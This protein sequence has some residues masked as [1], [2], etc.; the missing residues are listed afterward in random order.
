[1]GT[2]A[3]TLM[4]GSRVLLTTIDLQAEG[5]VASYLRA[6]RPYFTSPV[7]VMYVGAR[8]GASMSKVATIRRL[9]GDTWHFWRAVRSGNYALA[10]L[11]PSLNRKALVRDGMLALLARLAG[12]PV[13]VFI[14]GWV[15][16]CERA[17]L[18]R[19]MLRRLFTWTVLRADHIIVLAQDFAER[20]RL[21]GYRGAVSVLSTAVEKK[22]LEAARRPGECAELRVLFLAR[23]EREK[24]AL[25][26]VEAVQQLRQ[27]GRRIRLTLVGDGSD[28]AEIWERADKLPDVQ[29]LGYLRGAEKISVLCDNDVYLFPTEYGEGMPIS[30]LEAMAVGLPVIT[31]PVG[32]LRDFFVDG[33]MGYL[34]EST[35]P[36]VFADLLERFTVDRRREMG[37]YNATY[38]R[39]HFTGQVAAARVEA[40]Y[41]RVLRART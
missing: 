12:I 9:I 5:G 32:G 37:S 1:V 30:V 7:D 6:V 2:D 4:S 24:G 14:H 35:D 22:V 36:A 13:V 23:L 15:P 41:S 28:A 40:I 20:L 17:L 34:T 31:R 27:A 38:A 29:I 18:R 3:A 8:P 33:T 16:S 11:N 39:R 21:M 26:A 10:H 25:T 19:P